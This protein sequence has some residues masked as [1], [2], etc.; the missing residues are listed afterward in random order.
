MTTGSCRPGRVRHAAPF[1]AL[2]LSASLASVAFATDVFVD[3]NVNPCTPKTGTLAC[4]YTTVQAAINAAVVGDRVRVLPGVYLEQVFIK[5]G[6]DVMSENGPSV[7]TIDA[8]GQAFCTVR[9]SNAD[10]AST[11]VTHLSGFTITG[12]TGRPRSAANRGAADGAMSGGGIFIYNR[13]HVVIT[14]IIENNVRVSTGIIATVTNASTTV[15]SVWPTLSV[16]GMIRSGTILNARK[17]AVVV[18]KEPMPSW[19]RKFVS[20]PTPIAPADGPPSDFDQPT[21]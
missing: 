20:Q 8:T 6:V 1:L 14:P 7:T 13:N 16:P 3:D 10:P 9:F 5:N 21:T 15:G 2:L 12:G 11:L 18:A 19:S 17:S 4:P